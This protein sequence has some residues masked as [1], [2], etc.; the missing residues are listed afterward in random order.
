MLRRE[1]F[2]F[3][4]FFFWIRPRRDPVE[5]VRA[6]LQI[7]AVNNCNKKYTQTDDVNKKL[8]QNA[9]ARAFITDNYRVSNP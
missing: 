9:V 2:F 6:F 4:Y 7:L 8:V 5:I 3:L 1:S